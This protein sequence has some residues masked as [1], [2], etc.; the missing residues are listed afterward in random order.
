MHYKWP[1]DYCSRVAVKVGTK[2]QLMLETLF[3]KLLNPPRCITLSEL[4]PNVVPL[5]HTTNNITCKLP[6]DSKI[7]LSRSQVEV[8]P[9]FA[10][11]D[12]ESQ[13]KTHPFNPVDLSNCHSHQAYYTALSKGVQLQKVQL[14][15]KALMQ[16]R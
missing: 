12:F 11:T 14:S 4:P 7:S 5:T 9:N 16:E 10:M 3:V 15:F 8:L 2:G 1:R 13:G 6:D